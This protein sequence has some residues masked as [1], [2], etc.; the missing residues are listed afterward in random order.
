MITVVTESDGFDD[1]NPGDP[2]L[3]SVCNSICTDYGH[4]SG[5]I[6][7]IFSTDDR[8]SQLKKE[9]FQRNV[10]TDVISF[11]LEDKGEPVEGEIYISLERVAENAT[12]YNVEFINEL[13]RIMVHGVLHV[14]GLDDQTPKD[15]TEMTRLENHYLGLN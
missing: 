2:W 11:N 8:L 10:Y 6:T 14:M 9:F 7:F 12:N 1:P 13:K 4:D 5:S 15:K 3:K